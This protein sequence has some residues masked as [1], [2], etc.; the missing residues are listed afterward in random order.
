MAFRAA[1]PM[2]TFSRF[3]A[4]SLA[5][6]VTR[7]A[8]AQTWVGGSGNNVTTAANWSPS[9]TPANDGSAALS[10]GTTSFPNVSFDAA[11]SIASATI[12]GSTAYLIGGSAL[13]IGSGG[14]A[15]SST[16]AISFTNAITL[17]G[18]ATFST[19]AGTV[20]S[21]LTL[22]P[23]ALGSNNLTLHTTAGA[24]SI[25]GALT[26]TGAVTASGTAVTFLTSTSNTWSGGTT[27]NSGATLQIG[28][29]GGTSPGSLPGNVTDNGTLNFKPSNTSFNYSGVISGSGGIQM[30]GTN[31]LTLSN[32]NTYAGQTLIGGVSSG[33]T[34]GI[35]KVG[36][37][38]ALPTTTS[39]NFG[40]TGSITT[41]DVAANQK[42]KSFTGTNTAALIKIES[43]M[44]L[45]VELGNAG[46][47]TSFFGVISDGTAAGGQL[48]IAPSTNATP[49][50]V[51]LTGNNTYTGGTVI[52]SGGNL[53]LGSNGPTGSVVGDIA[54]AGTLTFNRGNA[55]TIAG[56]IS[57]AG[58]VT[59]GFSNGSTTGTTT[60]SAANTYSGNTR[61]SSGGLWVTNASGSATGTGNVTVTAGGSSLARFGGSGSITGSLTLNAKG[62][63]EPE[64]TL[65][66]GATTFNA[67]SYYTWRLLDAATGA[68]TGY[69]TL[70]VNGGLTLNA[71][72]SSGN[73]LTIAPFTYNGGSA[74]QAANF[75]PTQ[76][77]SF[78]LATSTGIS[79]FDAS[80]VAFDFS[81]FQNSY[82][83][84]WSVT[85]SG[86]NLLL[87][88]AGA[89]IPE[90][91][92][93]A[94]LAGLAVSALAWR[95][96]RETSKVRLS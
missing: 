35:L 81:N 52:Q 79:G 91:S 34:G 92:L 50:S 54:N 8:A 74:G 24:L 85:T 40:V 28:D 94:L 87:N 5:I 11:Y 58:T 72:A 9:G 1:V 70:A 6:L 88:Y 57:G 4:A 43:G 76:S 51:F 12:S 55:M 59:Q 27:I 18:N 77:Y 41:L 96:R 47:S 90:P 39:L 86:N 42:I 33:Q 30:L 15:D 26:G 75:D 21:N 31:T 46:S 13:S 14:I 37:A 69:G 38:D 48:V 32:Q 19:T 10:F 67:G 66:V 64:G 3:V 16:A 78:T 71:L 45:T 44:A 25:T 20:G 22:G 29:V 62:A 84:T 7:T 68:G 53:V 36:V 49:R 95:R 2:H 17:T 73:F 93:S 83:G 82:S 61:V 56:V 65:T 80:A 60:L 89:P 63:V 23:V